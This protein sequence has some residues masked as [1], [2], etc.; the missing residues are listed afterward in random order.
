M[1]WMFR[2]SLSAF[3]SYPG[4]EISM[5]I[6]YIC[7]LVTWLGGVKAAATASVVPDHGRIGDVAAGSST[8]INIRDD[9]SKADRRSSRFLRFLC[10]SILR[11]FFFVLL[12][13]IFR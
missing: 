10:V 1:K 2:C 5:I 4:I 11:P 6:S 13:G 12:I 3:R 9:E 7:L 8:R